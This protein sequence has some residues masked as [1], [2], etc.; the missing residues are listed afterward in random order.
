MTRY[1]SRKHNQ[2]Y[3]ETIDEILESTNWFNYDKVT[4]LENKTN[5]IVKQFILVKMN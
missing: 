5:T 3:L 2:Q 4:Y 1:L